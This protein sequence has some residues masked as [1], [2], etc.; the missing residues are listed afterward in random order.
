MLEL[1]FAV[2]HR[3]QVCPHKLP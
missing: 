3:E 1:N 2:Y